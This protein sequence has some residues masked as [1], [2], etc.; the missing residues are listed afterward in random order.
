METDVPG[1]PSVT[2]VFLAFNRR[3]QLRESLRC[4]VDGGGYPGRVEV[5]VVDNASEDGTAEMVAEEFPGVRV[6]ARKRNIGVSAWNDGFAVAGTDL[7]L[8]L[9][10]DCHLPAGGL[11]RAVEA[12]REH[13]ADLVSFA[14]TSTFDP[15]Y[16]FDHEYRTGLLSFWG[17]AALIKTGVLRELG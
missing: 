14:V 16:R 2:A 7:V 4:T 15:D 8:A 9:D 1:W 11:Q 10:D 5:V 17:C 6:I 13:E 3:D 12:A